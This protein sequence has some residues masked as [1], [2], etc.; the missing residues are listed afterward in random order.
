MDEFNKDYE[1][2]NNGNEVNSND[3]ASFA[4]NNFS[5][6]NNEPINFDD[7]VEFTEDADFLNELNF[8]NEEP[9]KSKFEPIDYT[10]ILPYMEKEK[11]SRGVKIFSFILAF[12]ILLSGACLGGYFIGKNSNKITTSKIKVDLTAKPKD[13]DEYSAAQVYELLNE[14]IVG[15][16]VYNKNGLASDASGVIYSKDGYVVTNDHI[17]SEIGAPQFRVYTYDGKEYD[18]EYV[19]GD[20]ISDLAVLKIKGKGFK[21]AVFGDSSQLVNGETVTAIG[22]PSDAT[23][24][25]SI[26]QGLISAVS[27]RMTTTSNYSAR[28]IQTDSA[29]NPGSSGGALVNMYGQVIGITASKLAGVEYDAIGFAIPTV[30]MKR[31]VEQLISDGEVTDRAKLGITYTEINSITEKMGEYSSTGLY[32]VSVGEDSDLYGKLKEGDIITHINGNKITKDDI[33]LDVI[34]NSKAGDSITVTVL[35]T[36]GVTKEYKA[37]L[38]ANVGQSSYSKILNNSNSSEKNDGT[39]DFPFGE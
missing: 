7:T 27:R 12:A 2:N 20:S 8:N 5:S 39:F 10:P 24:D 14:S 19:A 31:V 38:K 33:V 30:T 28:L 32:V 4:E 37:V 13:S 23:A 1:L 36:K 9:V 26:S 25:S 22:R 18:A 6:E 16:R 34:E 11:A 17:Y 3:E 15:I 29:I 35:N 21:P